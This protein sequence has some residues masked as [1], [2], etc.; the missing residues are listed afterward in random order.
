MTAFGALKLSP[1][2]SPEAADAKLNTFQLPGIQANSRTGGSENA[3]PLLD[4]GNLSGSKQE[5]ESEKTGSP[6]TLCAVNECATRSQARHGRQQGLYA[7]SGSIEDRKATV[8]GRKPGS[9]RLAKFGGKVDKIREA[10][11]HFMRK[12]TPSDDESV[13]NRLRGWLGTKTTNGVPDSGCK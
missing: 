11:F 10:G 7:R 6:V 12:E 8:P 5:S 2:G 4:A 9:A 13:G 3:H 1:H